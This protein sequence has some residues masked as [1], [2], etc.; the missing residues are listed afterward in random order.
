M[1]WNEGDALTI[2]EGYD[3]LTESPCA[4]QASGLLLEHESKKL[5]INENQVHGAFLKPHD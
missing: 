3:I 4:I 5:S 1:L 2:K